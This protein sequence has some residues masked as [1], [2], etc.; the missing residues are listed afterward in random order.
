MK[1]HAPKLVFQFLKKIYLNFGWFIVNFGCF[2]CKKLGDFS[3]RNWGFYGKKNW[4]PC[5][6]YMYLSKISIDTPS[7]VNRVTDTE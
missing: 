2:P 6:E 3:I 1:R 7:G 4:A 5:K